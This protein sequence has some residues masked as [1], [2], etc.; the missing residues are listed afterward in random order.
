MREQETKMERQIQLL[1]ADLKLEFLLNR[2]TAH[3][4][5]QLPP[6]SAESGTDRRMR[7]FQKTIQSHIEHDQAAL[8][9]QPAPEQLQPPQ[10]Q[11]RTQQTATQKSANPVA[12]VAAQPAAS[13]STR[14]SPA[15]SA[16]TPKRRQN[17]RGSVVVQPVPL[18]DGAATHFFIR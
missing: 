17:A 6:L 4:A 11:Q 2:R 14:P 13:P 10:Q 5:P 18:P 1:R 7:A 9:P 15:V 8:Q 12:T 16:A 3:S